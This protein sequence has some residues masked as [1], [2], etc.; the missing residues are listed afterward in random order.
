MTF[1]PPFGQ[2]DLTNCE[3][4]LIHLPGS[5]QPHGVLL[6]L[7]GQLSVVQC[8][9][10]AGM[11]FD[12]PAQELAGK[13]IDE[14]S[15]ALARE[16][17]ALLDAGLT[18]TPV[19]LNA[20]ISR[21]GQALDIEAVV[22]RTADENIILEL[23]P[24][25]PDAGEMITI[26]ENSLVSLVTKTLEQFG[27]APNLG[28]LSNTA[29]RAYRDLT[30]YDRVM[31]YKFDPD[32]HGQI[33]AEARDPRLDSL[34]GH[35]Y[36]ASDIPQRARSLY[37]RN[38]VRV[39]VDVHYEE[40]PLIPQ[41]AL[42]PG[43]EL[44]MSMCYLRS[45]SPLHLQYLKNMGVN[46]TLVVSIV[47]DGEL[48]GLVAA[49][50]DSPRNLSYA[51]RAACAL[52][53]EAISIRIAAIE[54]YSQARIAI[55]VRRLEQ[56]LIETTSSEGDWR[57]ALF[58]NPNILLRPLEATGAV[59]FFDNDIQTAGEVPST[60]ELRSLL[61][62]ID[63]KVEDR[64]YACSSIST[65]NPALG[66]LTPLASGVLAV[67]LSTG[68]PE[69][70]VWLRKEQ[71]ESVTW[72]GDPKKP[73]IDNDPMKLSPRR[74]FAAWS[75]IVRGKALPWSRAE[76]TMARAIGNSLIDIILQI[77][78]VRLLI[79]NH[80]IQE[81]RGSMDASREPVAIFS[82]ER[83]IFCNKSCKELLPSPPGA[84]EALADFLNRFAEVKE[85]DLDILSNIRAGDS[86]RGQLTLLSEHRENLPVRV[87]IELIPGPAGQELGIV[88][89]MIDLTPSVMAEKARAHLEQSLGDV[90]ELTEQFDASGQSTA[91]DLLRAIVSNASMAAMDIA[92]AAPDETDSSS[93]EEVEQATQ[94]ANQLY[95]WI[96]KSYRK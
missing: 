54:N 35:R 75:E 95:D 27:E 25:P 13:T 63:Q 24:I 94:R 49:H 57:L 17:V 46:A 7:N 30:G 39:L 82:Q 88:L 66:S 11:V 31:I 86:W 19:P 43:R 53:G 61:A 56:R 36:P 76:L 37:I 10:N 26:D 89:S 70:L 5:I 8:S 23:I 16:L 38:R 83:L 81:I 4:E 29:A 77:H 12:H 22:H 18:E 44:D 69:Y 90:S 80:Q 87:S 78:G 59:L 6:V 71:L 33:I 72:A 79:A 96:R 68:R 21:D 28:A 14:L 42:G 52:M 1:S 62:W 73:M 93:F 84:N 9:A 15:E 2:A 32:G 3:R 40:S 55:Q 51:V 85:S 74:S 65:E 45:M 91:D 48:W 50:H 92:D 67:K 34:L 47:R 20:Q 60:P 41:D 58:R 64:L